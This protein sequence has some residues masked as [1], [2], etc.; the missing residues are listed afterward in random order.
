VIK[1]EKPAKRHKIKIHQCARSLKGLL[2]KEYKTTHVKQSEWKDLA[3]DGSWR[4]EITAEDIPILNKLKNYPTPFKGSYGLTLRLEEKEKYKTEDE[5]LIRENT[6]NMNNPKKLLD[7]RE[8]KAWSIDWQKRYI[9]FDFNR[10]SE[11]KSDEFFRNTKV[12]IPKISLTTQSVVFNND[13][14][15]RDSLLSVDSDLEMNPNVICSLINNIV[16]RYYTFFVLRVN[17]L[18]GSKRSQFRPNVVR[19]FIIPP[20]LEDNLPTLSRL[21]ELSRDCHALAHE[22]VNGDQELSAWIE[23]KAQHKYRHFASYSDTNLSLMAG[24]V[25]IEDLSFDKN[26]R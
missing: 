23:E 11:P 17:A 8:I 9:D 26:G 25:D 20:R 1:K 10:I 21:E 3:P 22:M 2:E 19:Y 18:Q 5:I 13:F 16:A 7:G 15:F 12:I 24:S 14:I 6:I 4:M